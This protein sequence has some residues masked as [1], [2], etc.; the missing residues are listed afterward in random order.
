MTTVA[1]GR[2]TSAPVP[3]FSAIGTKLNP[4]TKAVINTDLSLI[5]AP[6][7]IPEISSPRSLHKSRIYPSHFKMQNLTPEHYR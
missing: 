2:C 3:M 6:S 1:S 7:I 5:I 4:A